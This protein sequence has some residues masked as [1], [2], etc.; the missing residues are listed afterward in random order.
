MASIVKTALLSGTVGIITGMCPT[1]T[2][3]TS[4]AA[5]GI[6]ASAVKC[7]AA[8]GAKAIYAADLRAPSPDLS[9]EGYEGTVTGVACD[10][11]K[12]DQVEALVRQ[13]IKEQGRLDWFVS[14]RSA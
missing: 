8:A 6:G 14:A 5:S 10:I 1:F 2:Q 3:L 7:F 9:I 12:E 4:G 11:T 13:V